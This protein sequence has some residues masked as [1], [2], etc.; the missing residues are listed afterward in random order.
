MIETV[1]V[2][3][4]QCITGLYVASYDKLYCRRRIE[5]QEAFRLGRLESV[6][7]SVLLSV[8]Q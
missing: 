5:R 1:C 8:V 3:S 4:F 6:S 7:L 2:V